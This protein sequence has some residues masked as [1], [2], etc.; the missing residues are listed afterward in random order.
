M[1]PLPKH[2]GPVLFRLSEASWNDIQLFS[3]FEYA[4]PSRTRS[5]IRFRRC[6]RRIKNISAQ[7][8]RRTVT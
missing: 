1:A 7:F 8:F 4:W 5:R 6:R 2:T 3:V